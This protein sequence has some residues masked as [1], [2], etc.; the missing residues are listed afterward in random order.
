VTV[1][2]DEVNGPVVAQG[3]VTDLAPYSRSGFDFDITPTREG[4]MALYVTVDENGALAEDSEANN[5]QRSVMHVSP[6]GGRVLVVDDDGANDSEDTV[7][8][9]L[10]VLGIPFDVVTEHVEAATMGNYDVVI[11][12]GGLER[13]QGQMDAGDRA[14]VAAYLDNGGKL[15]Y[16]SPR[17]AAALGEPTG[18]TNPL[19]TD[20]MAPFLADYF[21]ATYADTEQV[22]GGLVT[23]TGD[24]LGSATYATDVF[25]GR[26]LQDVF[27]AGSSRRAARVRSWVP[28]SKAMVTTRTS[29][30]C[31]SA[32]T[33]HSSSPAPMP[34]P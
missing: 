9:A 27:K 16:A 19:A 22:G 24:I 25:P 5:T 13:Y 12:E 23:G 32:S 33:R 14:A 21:G 1:H 17:A 2:Q 3:T 30:P 31:S 28:A 7:T 6:A 15:L 11:W 8:G 29:A 34:S 26:P 20:D 18:S 4:P 10:S